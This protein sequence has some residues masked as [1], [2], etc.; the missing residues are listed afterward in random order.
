MDLAFIEV[1]RKI[2]MYVI[3]YK[4]VKFYQSNAVVHKV[5][6]IPTMGRQGR[7]GSMTSKGKRTGKVICMNKGLKKKY[8]RFSTFIM[9]GCFMFH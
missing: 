4:T 5:Q 2:D 6:Y 3:T 8:S 1:K 7:L 9:T